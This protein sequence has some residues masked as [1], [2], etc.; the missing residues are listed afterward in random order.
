MNTIRIPHDGH[1]RVAVSIT[2]NNIIIIDR[3]EG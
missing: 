2:T 1:R 3:D